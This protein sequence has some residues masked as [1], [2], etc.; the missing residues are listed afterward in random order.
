MVLLRWLGVVG[1]VDGLGNSGYEGAMVRVG[2]GNRGIAFADETEVAWSRF[3]ENRGAF[4]QKWL[5][6]A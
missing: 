1:H 4:M 6:W 2:L 5:G 3:V